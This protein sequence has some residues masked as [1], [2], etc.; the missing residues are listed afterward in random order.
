MRGDEAFRY[1]DRALAYLHGRRHPFHAASAKGAIAAGATD[2]TSIAIAI[3]GDDDERRI[4]LRVRSADEATLATI[5]VMRSLGHI[6][7]DAPIEEVG[8]IFG[9][10]AAGGPCSPI[11]PGIACANRGGPAGTLGCLVQKGEDTFILS[12]NHVLALE[13]HAFRKEIVQPERG[14]PGER[15]IGELTDKE[16]LAAVGNLMDAAVARVIVNDLDSSIFNGVTITG[17]RTTPLVSGEMLFKFGQTT[18][19]TSGTFKSIT[20][21]VTVE[22]R[23]GTYTFDQQIEIDSPGTPFSNGGDSGALVY[24]QANRAVGIL[25]GGNGTT[26]SYVTPIDRILGRF[27]ATLL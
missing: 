7:E 8:R 6:P 13:D 25:F 15:T 1:H 22:M 21:N 14:I 5:A 27:T 10:S 18:D 2:D 3:E 11:Q 20:S 9:L 23:F 16:V 24:D 4:A 12:A 19:E 26:R 17:V